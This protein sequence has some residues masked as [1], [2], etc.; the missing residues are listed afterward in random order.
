MCTILLKNFRY[1]TA[2]N[3]SLYKADYI[4]LYVDTIKKEFLELTHN[5]SLFITSSPTNGKESVEEGYVARSPGSEFYGDGK[6]NIAFL[7]E[8]DAFSNDKL[9]EILEG[10]TSD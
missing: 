4:K 10:S 2:G 6:L 9:A 7:T 5:R 3:F 8:K 1:N